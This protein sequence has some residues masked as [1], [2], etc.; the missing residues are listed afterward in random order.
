M[1][2]I[3]L[4]LLFGLLQSWVS[5]LGCKSVG[6][7]V[8]KVVSISVLRFLQWCINGRGVLLQKKKDATEIKKKDSKEAWAKYYQANFKAYV[9]THAD[10]SKADVGDLECVMDHLFLIFYLAFFT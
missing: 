6:G 10:K 3:R 8:L 9:A 7:E 2:I 5:T 4:L 1:Y